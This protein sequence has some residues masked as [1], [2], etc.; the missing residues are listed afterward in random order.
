MDNN[1]AIFDTGESKAAFWQRTLKAWKESGL[2][3]QEYQRQNNLSKNTF[4]Y[5]KRKLMPA[6]QRRQRFVPV[7]VPVVSRGTSS[8]DPLGIR[9]HWADSVTIEVGSRFDP[10]NLRKV[11]DVLKEY[12]G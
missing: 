10:Q 4:V 7:S 3:G 1:G 12:A 2:C 9:I 11:L 5:W 6:T 8:S